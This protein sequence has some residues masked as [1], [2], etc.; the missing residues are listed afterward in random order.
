M[1]MKKSDRNGIYLVWGSGVLQLSFQRVGV[2]VISP[3]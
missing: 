1:Y 3:M 2:E